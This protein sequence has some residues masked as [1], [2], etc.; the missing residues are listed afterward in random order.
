MY[1]AKILFIV[2]FHS[3]PSK[4][5]VVKNNTL[6]INKTFTWR[7]K[8]WAYLLNIPLRFEQNC[9]RRR[10]KEMRIHLIFNLKKKIKP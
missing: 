1:Q 2:A 5:K 4:L 3:L 6:S 8:Y 10:E 9:W 7:Q